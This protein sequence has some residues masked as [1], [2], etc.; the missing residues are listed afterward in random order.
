MPRLTRV[1]AGR[2]LTLLVLS[3]GSSIMCFSTL[4]APDVLNGNKIK[5][6]CNTQRNM[7]LL[8]GEGQGF[9]GCRP[10]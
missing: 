8:Q 5:K 9:P 4:H 6:V 7:V 1:F 2:T 3:Q 10:L